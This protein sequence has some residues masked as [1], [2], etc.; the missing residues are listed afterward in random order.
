MQHDSSRSASRP[1]P[2]QE[3]HWP[4]LSPAA[5][6]L[7]CRC[8]R[9]GEGRLFRGFLTLA[10]KCDVCGLDYDFADS[11]DG[12]AVFIM[13]ACGFIVVG[14]ALWLELNFEPG[15]LLHLLTTLP[16]GIIV[17]LAPLRPLKGLMIALQYASRA[18]EGGPR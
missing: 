6:G 3:Q 8:P 5:T 15:V 16:L 13:L 18:G 7:R 14:F 10:P 1:A 11:G 9:C 12:P 2:A 4:P 17:C